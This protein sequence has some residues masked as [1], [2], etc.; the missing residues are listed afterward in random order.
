MNVLAISYDLYK[1]PSRAYQELVD[2]LK[3][4]PSWCH[5]TESTWYVATD[6]TP[7]QMYNNLVPHLHR[8]DKVIISPVV[9]G[10]WWSQGL[11]KD[12]LDWLHATLDLKRTA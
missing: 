5:P 4:F 9:K 1:E 8:W 10:A 3:A 12:V 11:P 6:L 2:A 7:E